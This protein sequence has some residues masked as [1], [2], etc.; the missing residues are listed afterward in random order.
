MSPEAILVNVASVVVFCTGLAKNWMLAKGTLKP[1]YVL[2]V[3]MGLFGFLL[4]F[5][6]VWAQ[7]DML[8]I[9]SF[10]L[11]NLWVMAMGIK[12][13]LRLRQ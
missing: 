13:L 11:L 9:L 10:S 5:G 1:V 7:P 6:V 12:G 4:N 8:G 3:V 2:N